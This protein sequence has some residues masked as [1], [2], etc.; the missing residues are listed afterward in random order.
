MTRI[1][2]ERSVTSGPH[3]IAEVLQQLDYVIKK[4]LD[5]TAGMECF[6][7]SRRAVNWNHGHY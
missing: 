3:I 4:G 5:D 2:K 6:E 7:I 1:V